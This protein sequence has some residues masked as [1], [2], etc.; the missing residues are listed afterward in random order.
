MFALLYAD[1]FQLSE[2]EKGEKPFRKTLETE[3]EKALPEK[4][5]KTV[6]NDR[7]SLDH[8]QRHCPLQLPHLDV[9]L[10]GGHRFAASCLSALF[11]DCVNIRLIIAMMITE[12]FDPP[13]HGPGLQ[14]TVM[15]GLRIAY[16][17]EKEKALPAE[18]VGVAFGIILRGLQNAIDSEKR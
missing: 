7:S 16:T 2:R 13:R 12:G 18:R 9:V 8:D 14:E 1:C 5:E 10:F 11:G 4:W 15:K 17:A 6:L 3:L